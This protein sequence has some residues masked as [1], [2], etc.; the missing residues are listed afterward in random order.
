[1]RANAEKYQIDGEKLAVVGGSAGGH[2]ALLAGLM[3]DDEAVPPEAPYDDQ[4]SK[5]Q[6]VVNYFGPADLNKPDWPPM[7]EQM[8]VNLIGGDRTKLPEEYGAA[9]PVSH[10]DA[11]D[12]PVITFH[13]TA[14]ALVPYNQATGLHAAMNEAGVENHLETLT[15]QGHGFSPGEMVRT[16]EMSRKFLVKHFGDPK[17]AGQFE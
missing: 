12:P 7:V 14:D 11:D 6:A 15:G 9:S 13:G 8:L 4:S 2:L 10:I 16:L 17:S 5:P 1:M 3:D